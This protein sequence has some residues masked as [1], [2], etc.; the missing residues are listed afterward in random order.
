MK[1]K[2]NI[3]NIKDC[4][5]KMSMYLFN[6]FNDSSNKDHFKQYFTEIFSKSR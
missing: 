4:F 5:L 1:N 6:F 2:K 3:K